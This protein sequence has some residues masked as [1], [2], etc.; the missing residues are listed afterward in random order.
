MLPKVSGSRVLFDNPAKWP[1]KDRE[2]LWRKVFHSL[3]GLVDK[4]IPKKESEDSVILTV[5]ALLKVPAS[6]WKPEHRSSEIKKITDALSLE[7]ALSQIQVKEDG[8]ANL[9]QRKTCPV[10]GITHDSGFT[11][12]IFPGGDTVAIAG[13]LPDIVRCVHAAHEKGFPNLITKNDELVQICGGYFHPS[14]AFYDLK[15]QQTYRLLFD[16]SRRGFIALRGFVV[17]S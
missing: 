4:L 16:T 10:C 11:Q 15:Q 14:K 12:F 7:G 3:D 13:V 8:M 2:E 17:G 6:R 1:W 9:L 5:N